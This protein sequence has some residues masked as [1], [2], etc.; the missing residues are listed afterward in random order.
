[1]KKNLKKLIFLIIFLAI[2]IIPYLVFAQNTDTSGSGVISNMTKV[3]GN[4]GYATGETDQFS[5][6][7]LAGKIVSIALSL[8]GVIFLSLT[9]YG[10]F[11]WMTAQ[12]DESQVEKAKGVIKNSVIG[13]IIIVGCTA[14]YLIVG[15]ILQATLT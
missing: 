5:L 7:R 1:M 4:G 11:L 14:I 15:R 13:L 10:G 3:A 8:L 6:A 12:G 9:L 2:L